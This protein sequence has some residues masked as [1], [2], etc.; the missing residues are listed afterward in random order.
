[1]RDPA[2][3]IGH[4]FRLS[5][6]GIA[7]A[8]ATSGDP[9]LVRKGIK[10]REMLRELN[11][12]GVVDFRDNY[13]IMLE[14]I[15]QELVHLG[16]IRETVYA[17]IAS[18]EAVFKTI[19][20]HNQYLHSQLESYK[21]Y[22]QNV[23]SQASSGDS[24]GA[25]NVALQNTAAAKKREQ[26]K[27]A[28]ANTTAKFTHMQLERDGVIAESNVPETRKASIYFQIASPDPGSFIIYLFFKG[29]ESPI[30]EMEL[31]LDDL[32]EKQQDNIQL[33]DLEYVQLHV[34]K[35]LHLLNRTFLRR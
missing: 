9:V 31:T 3:I 28:A 13:A 27:Y 15:G 17:E 12:A 33:L 35:L 23:R 29:R 8:A 21:A 14:E 30:L 18:L 2:T 34:G 22:L 5:L 1:A 24:A 20:D 4:T 10:V 16:N 26:K 32:L 25:G 7:D 19:G 11:E 6:D